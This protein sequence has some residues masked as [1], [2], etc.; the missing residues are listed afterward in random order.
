MRLLTHVGKYQGEVVAANIL[1]E[2]R[3]ANYEAIPDVV[4]TDPQAASVGATEAPFSA[5]TPSSEVAKT[6]TYTHA[7]AQ[8]ERLPDPPQRRRPVDRRLCPGPEAG[9]WLQQATLAI[10]AKVPLDVLRDTIQPFPTF[11][12]IY[13]AT[14]KALHKQI[15][16]GTPAGRLRDRRPAVVGGACGNTSTALSGRLEHGR[17]WVRSRWN[18]GV[19][20]HHDHPRPDGT[21]ERPSKQSHPRGGTSGQLATQGHLLRLWRPPCS[22]ASGAPWPVRCRRR[23]RTRILASKPVPGRGADTPLA[24]HR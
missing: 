19:S 3:E 20:R 10:R 14:L 23:Q 8:I 13:V 1:G 9:E 7:Y 17:T 22:R 5:T 4:Y 2:P 12:E 11:S 18:R 15:R 6:A 21:S 16:A 24:P